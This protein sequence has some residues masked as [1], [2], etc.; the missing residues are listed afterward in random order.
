MLV[1][2][3]GVAFGGSHSTIAAGTEIAGVDVGGLTAAEATRLLRAR[4]AAG[5]RTPVAFSA[6][7]ATTAFL[8]LPARRAGELGSRSAGGRFAWDGLGPAARDLAAV[9]P[10]VRWRQV[11]PTLTAYPAALDYKLG[12]LEAAVNRSGV[13]AKVKRRGLRISVVEGRAGRKLDRAAAA[14]VIVGALGGLER[15][16]VVPLPVAST[17]VRVSAADLAISAQQARTALSAPVRLAYGETRWRLPRW[18]IAPLLDLPAGGGTHLAIAGQGAEAYLKRLA[19]AVGRKPQDARFQV[20]AG[21]KIVIR[22]SRPGLELEMA[23]T[24]KAIAAAAFSP[25]NRT[26]H[27]VV[28]AAEPARTTEAARK[29]GITAVVASY[30]TT[31]GGTP[32]RLHNVQLVSELIDQT[33]IAPGA[34]FSFNGTTGDRTA[35]KGFEEAPV[36]INGELQNGLGGGI[37]QV[38]TTVFNAAFDA[39]LP[40]EERA[41]HALYISHYPLGRDATVNYP[42]LDLKFSN[43]TGHWLLL[44]TFVGSAR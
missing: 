3:A 42:D 37:C 31:Y 44:R 10:G 17:A 22:P 9:R 1:V 26:A 11:E 39:G 21:G 40:I 7:G 38:S 33:L 25:T 2:L 16:R 13:D 27:L 15:G 32:G 43:D 34:T 19:G 20:T 4:A 29:M 36:I 6:G 28:A 5:Q 14:D 18:R 23:A 8:R 41:N 24:A 30:T 12:Q 35:A